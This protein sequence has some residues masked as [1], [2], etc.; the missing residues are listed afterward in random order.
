MLNHDKKQNQAF[1][2]SFICLMQNLSMSQIQCTVL[3]NLA[4]NV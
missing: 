4:Q 1:Q 2:P 3:H